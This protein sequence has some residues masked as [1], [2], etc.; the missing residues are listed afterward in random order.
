MIKK[1]FRPI[2]SKNIE[3]VTMK[4]LTRFGKFLDELCFLMDDKSILVAFVCDAEVNK[5]Q[6]NDCKNLSFIRS[7]LLP[8]RLQMHFFPFSSKKCKQM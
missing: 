2:S 1:D 6:K 5:S 3:T 7:L 4:I 8:F